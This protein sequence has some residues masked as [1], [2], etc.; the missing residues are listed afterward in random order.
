MPAPRPL[1]VH[2]A[3][4]QPTTCS[5][6]QRRRRGVAAVAVLTLLMTSV[7][8]A[9]AGSDLDNDGF[10][11]LVVGV[12]DEDV[13]QLDAGGAIN[14]LRGAGG[15][16]TVARDRL[17]TQA[18]LGGVVEVQDRFGNAIA[19]GDFDN[20][21]FDDVA[22]GVPG[23]DY[24]GK[25]DAGVV[26]VLYGSKSGARPR[27][28]QLLSQAGKMKG[29]NEA[30][31]FFGAVLASGDF[32]N[33]GFDDLAI[34]TPG[35]DVGGAVAA[36]GVI[37][38][39]GGRN[40]IKTSG[41]QA[42]TQK[43]KVPGKAEYLDTLGVSLAVGDFNNDNFDDLAMGAPGESIGSADSAGNVVVLYGRKKGL[44]RRGTSLTQSGVVPGD[45]GG[46]HAFGRG[47][48]AGDFDGNGVDDLVV[49]VSGE[50]RLVLFPGAG[51]GLSAGTSS[52]VRAGDLPGSVSTGEDFGKVLAAGNFDGGADDEL[53]VGSQK[54][55]VAGVANAGQV[56]ILGGGV[57]GIPASSAF[58]IDQG[59]LPKATPEPGDQLGS[60]LR[61]GD[62]NN[63]NYDDLAMGSAHEDVGSKRDSGVVYV[64]YGSASS[65]QV[66]GADRFHQG[67]KK[68]EGKAEARDHFGAGL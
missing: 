49:G 51:G 15:G 14:I 58:G 46:G 26:H 56:I 32:D 29:A 41:S 54:S 7:G 50:R 44:N 30:G 3:V 65:L 5:Q 40:G 19:Y 28:A 18:D 39:Y 12:P 55:T 63:D 35:E 13:A 57:A 68:V 37:V 60:A 52:S 38:A 48:A 10:D 8:V 47:L 1:P 6:T 25:Q 61:V 23:E 4:A 22:V 2:D 59:N 64:A 36:G 17:Y 20:D 45:V 43:G 24:K 66:A 9:G 16:V 34:G 53:A 33:D 11:D 27:S 62:F 31:D 42:L 21:G 67:T